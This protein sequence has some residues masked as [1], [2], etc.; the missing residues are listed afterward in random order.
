VEEPVV[1]QQFSFSQLTSPSSQAPSQAKSTFEE[2]MDQYS[3]DED[4]DDRSFVD[5]FSAWFKTENR[6]ERKESVKRYK[7]WLQKNDPSFRTS[8]TTAD[9]SLMY[10]TNYAGDFP[11]FARIAQLIRA[12]PGSSGSIER[13]F[14]KANDIMSSKRNSLNTSTVELILQVS[15]Y[16][17]VQN[18]FE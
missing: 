8:A 16:P 3:G 5:E 9:R 1:D 7:Q 6:K 2:E 12:T 4:E 17:N 10:F 15:S 11:T 13:L 14:S 18:L